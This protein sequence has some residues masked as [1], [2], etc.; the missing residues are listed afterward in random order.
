MLWIARKNAFITTFCFCRSTCFKKKHLNHHPTRQD[1]QFFHHV[2]PIN[3]K[4]WQQTPH[5]NLSCWVPKTWWGQMGHVTSCDRW[6]NNKQSSAKQVTLWSTNSLLWII[7]ICNGKINYKWPFS[8]AML[9]YQRVT[10]CQMWRYICATRRTY[11]ISIKLA[12]WGCCETV[13]ISPCVQKTFCHAK[14]RGFFIGPGI[15]SKHPQPQKVGWWV[16]S[17]KPGDSR[18]GG[19]FRNMFSTKVIFKTYINSQITLKKKIIWNS[20][21][22]KGRERTHN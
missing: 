13:D 1:A 10:F 3:F 5:R 4:P 19:K 12:W 21:S 17:E 11:T 16:L 20:Y 15:L 18:G 22:T 9:N 7:I 2:T 6:E 8:K 14:H